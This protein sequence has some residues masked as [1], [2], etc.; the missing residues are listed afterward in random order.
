MRQL[1]F[2][3]DRR[4]Q[5]SNIRKQKAGVQEVL[6]L[7]TTLRDAW[8]EMLRQQEMGAAPADELAVPTVG[9]PS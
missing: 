7:V 5:E 8:A 6:G 4:L 9:G 1:Y 3:L 2:Y